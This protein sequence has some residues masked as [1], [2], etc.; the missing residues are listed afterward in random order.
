M[1]FIG[2]FCL[3]LLANQGIAQKKTQN[4]VVRGVIVDRAS[5]SGIGN[6]Y[7]EILNQYPA[8]ATVTDATGNFELSDVPVGQQR[9]KIEAS[10]YYDMLHSELVVAGKEAV[11]TIGLDEVVKL[12]VAVI[13]GR[14]NKRKDQG[15]LR[16]NKLESV[17][18]MNVISTRTLNIAE[19][20]RYASGA[21]DPA[22][23]V[24]NFP[25]L[26]NLNDSQNDIVSRGNPSYG[27]QWLIEGIPIDNP[28]HFALTG[29]TGGIFP[30]LNNNLLSNSDFIN[31][32]MAASYGNTSSGVFDI[33]LR[34]GNNQRFEF[35]GQLSAL[36]AEFIA[37]GPFK[38]GKSSFIIAA[39][40]GIFNI[41][42][43]LNIKFGS[44]ASP[45]YYDVNLKVDIAKTAAGRFSF[46]ALGGIA[47]SEVLMENVDPND[48]F[49][50]QGYDVYAH[51]ET[52]L[53]GLTH[54][55]FFSERSSI[56]TTLF[57]SIK[58]Y[59]LIANKASQQGST[60]Y[61]ERLEQQHRIGIN[62]IFN[63]KINSNLVVRAGIRSIF[64]AFSINSQRVDNQK[65]IY[66][67]HDLS[68]LLNSYVQGQY[69]FS[70]RFVLTL[71]LHGMYWTYS[72]K[73]WAIEPR[74]A[75]NW[76][77]GKRH[78]IS[79]GYGWHSVIQPTIFAFNVDKAELGT[80]DDSYRKLGPT[81]SHHL[82]LSH[83]S[84]LGRDWLIRSSVYGHYST[85]VVVSQQPSSA[86]MINFGAIDT[87]DPLVHKGENTG[88]G[89]NY[90]IELS[91]EKSLSNGYYSLLS[92]SY[93]RAFYRASD[94]IW[95]PS[96]YDIQY[97]SALVIGKS[98]KIGKKRRNS[99]YADFRGTIRG[100]APYT[101]IDLEASRAAEVEVLDTKRSYSERLGIYK[102]IDLRVGAR[103]NH[104][105]KRISHH[106]Y[107]NALNCF[108]FVNE[109]QVKYNPNTQELVRVEILGFFPNLFYQVLF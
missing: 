37:E 81:R 41:L 108:N 42:Q 8:R 30:L 52:A 18:K 92:G 38:R 23:A 89:L 14:Q 98:F 21:G 101:P 99:F 54:Q 45:Q 19:V 106:I 43:A 80:Y 104:R 5:G 13:S 78:Q 85:D 9:L 22:R 74:L 12:P 35:A 1:I 17:D 46:F 28:H 109:V 50:E 57:Y 20:T 107:I 15:R 88:L 77:L 4:Q 79:L 59:G 83:N 3:C 71:G 94:L 60:P 63:Q 64:K 105:K 53:A 39:R 93:Q 68:V 25:G 72:N 31:G 97:L 27:I 76:Y 36:G 69:K 66:E 11:L 91:L 51:T 44:N 62:S 90:G 33:A 2:I 58:R 10:G 95:R 24:S 96:A 100:G 56:K 87:F 70:N 49:A 103:F 67:S 82:I 29:A 6:A 73:S 34:N 32:A 55:K 75:L 86:S 7:I 47:R 26:Y 61:S 65:S 84:Y 16:N 102:R 40:S 48:I